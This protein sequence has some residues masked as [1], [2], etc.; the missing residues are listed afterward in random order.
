MF[1]LI[2]LTFILSLLFSTAYAQRGERLE[3]VTIQKKLLPYTNPLSQI[4]QIDNPEEPVMKSPGVKDRVILGK[5]TNIYRIHLE[6]IDAHLAD[7]PVRVER[8]IEEA[9]ENMQLLIDDFPEVKDNVRFRELYRTIMTEYKK[10]YNITDEINPAEGEIFAI[11][12]EILAEIEEWDTERF[13]MPESVRRSEER[14]VGK[15]CRSRGWND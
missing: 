7:D 5:I 12:E 2:R 11:H 10:F 3:E 1:K 15:E 8:H 14:R 9:V 6:V 13:D 4:R